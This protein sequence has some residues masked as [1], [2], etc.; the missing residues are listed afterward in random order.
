MLLITQKLA[1]K[2]RYQNHI[3]LSSWA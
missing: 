3:A 1:H 2:Q